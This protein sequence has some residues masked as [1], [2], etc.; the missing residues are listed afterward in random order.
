MN[1]KEK[2]DETAEKIYDF[3]KSEKYQV[4]VR[5]P[6]KS[7]KAIQVKSKRPTNHTKKWLS[8]NR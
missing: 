7:E 2:V 6:K 8:K 3:I 1:W 4:E 5:L